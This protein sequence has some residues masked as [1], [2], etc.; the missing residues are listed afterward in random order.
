M[1]KFDKVYDLIIEDII[2]S[3]T[4]EELK[5]RQKE[6][7][8]I[9]LKK[10]FDKLVEENKMFNNSDGSYDIDGNIHIPNMNITSLE[11]LPYVI[12][13]IDGSFICFD[14]NLTTLK[15]CPKEI[16][17]S[18]LHRGNFNCS[19]NKLTSLEGCPN[20]IEGIFNCSQNKLTNLKYIKEIHSSFDCSRNY[21]TSLEGLPE[22]I[23]GYLSVYDNNLTSLEGCPKKIDGNFICSWNMLTSLEGCPEEVSHDFV[24]QNMKHNVVFKEE[25]IRK[26]CKV[27]GKIH[28]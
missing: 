22:I 10:Y 17:R 20:I 24:I 16:N 2:Q 25:D 18:F 7:S 23:N 3:V 9:Q 27:G 4:P 8:K 21:L 11:D 1:D 15:G 13:S 26:V 12:D 14:N 28:V 5:D 6:Y 19:D